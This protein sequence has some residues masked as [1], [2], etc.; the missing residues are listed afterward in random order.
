MN[1]LGGFGEESQVT[2]FV[3]PFLRVTQ[4]A[5]DGSYRW[6]FTGQVCRYSSVFAVTVSFFVFWGLVSWG[7]K[8]FFFKE[9]TLG[10]EGLPG[11]MTFLQ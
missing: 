3:G 6:P 10:W 2:I 8:P 9:F 4:L 11:Y 1:R 5:R 7:L